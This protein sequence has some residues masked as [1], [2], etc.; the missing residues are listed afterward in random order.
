MKRLLTLIPLSILMVILLAPVSVSAQ[1]QEQPGEIPVQVDG[2]PV[3]FDVH[4]VIQDGRTLVPFRA[5]AE[6]LNVEVAWDGTT[7]AITATDGKTSISLQIGNKTA[8]RNDTPISLDVPPL[9]LNGRTLIP[10]RF[11]SEAFDCQVSWRGPAEGIRIF[12]S[13][14]AITVIGF[15]ALGDA[16]TSSWTDLFGKPYPEKAQGHT[17]LVSGLA[18][19]WYSVDQ[20]GNLLTRSTTGW[21]RPS[22]WENVLAAAAGYGLKPEMMIHVTDEDGTI[23]SLLA[24]QAAVT[25]AISAITAEAEPYTGVNLDFE[26]LGRSETGED[27]VM[28]KQSFT[29][30]VRLLTEQLK[31]K[32]KGLTLTIH[33]PNSVYRGYDYEALGGIAD[34]IIIM[35]Y[36]YGPRPEP[37]VLVVEAVEAARAVVPAHKLI[38]GISAPY[39]TPESILTKV[40]IARRYNLHGIALW[41]L[42]LISDEMWAVLKTSVQP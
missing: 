40:G 24:D 19:G 36:D 22:G 13:S 30:F 31:T 6:A 3:A 39:E 29:S 18:L 35:A 2:L 41:R 8:E 42:G 20:E 23:S 17:D 33:A 32:G 14:E 11:F 4:P 7:Q 25:R 38:L 16:Q 26:G 9:I 21:Q 1:A 27:L 10:L 28:V 37:V 5:I 15:Y 34:R 12:S